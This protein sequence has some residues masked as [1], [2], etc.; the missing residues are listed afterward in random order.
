MEKR[1]DFYQGERVIKTKGDYTFEG[2][3]VSR[4]TKTTGAIRYV[5]ENPAGI[6][7]IYSAKDLEL[8]DGSDL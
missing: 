4:F 6:L 2:V 8:A 7:H 5:V 3:V 1:I